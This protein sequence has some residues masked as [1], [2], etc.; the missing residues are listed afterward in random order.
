M[1][2]P[3][4][5][6]SVRVK[7]GKCKSVTEHWCRPI[8]EAFKLAT[9]LA[10]TSREYKSIAKDVAYHLAKDLCPFSTVELPGFQKMVSKFNPCYQL[11]TNTNASKNYFSRNAVSSLYTVTILRIA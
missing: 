4:E 11:P 3:T 7:K 2:Y 10:S 9:K 6:Q 8:A 5:Y 1:Y